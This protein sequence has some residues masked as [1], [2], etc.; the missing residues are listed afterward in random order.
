MSRINQIPE[1]INNYNVYDE[2]EKLVGISGEITL[3]TL[4]PL[5]ESVSGA[6]IAGEVDSPTIGHFGSMTIDIPFRTI[7][8]QTFNLM[9]PKAQVIKL[10][11]AQ[12]N[13]DTAGGDYNVT[14]LRIIL[15]TQPKSIDLG[16]IAMGTPTN[17]TN[18][19]EVLYIKIVADGKEVL[20]YDKY[21]FI[22]RVNGTDYLQNVKD[23]I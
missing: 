20:E 4:E 1:K 5:T 11:A 18:T 21:N 15:K 9:E 7:L 17:T 6:G 13:Y 3:P 19:L 12:Q 2:S 14:P 10:R 22:Y 23:M 16:S 8:D